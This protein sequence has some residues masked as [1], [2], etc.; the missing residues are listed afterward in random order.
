[1]MLSFVICLAMTS[2]VFTENVWAASKPGRIKKSSIK[3]TS[4]KTNSAVVKYGKSKGAKKYQVAYKPAG[5]KWK[6]KTTKK[7]KLILKSLK[8][9]TKY[10]VKVRGLRGK[11]TKGKWSSAVVFTTAADPSAG[12]STGTGED[13]GENAWTG[14]VSW[15]LPNNCR[16]KD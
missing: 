6:Y 8:A 1:M 14:G 12:E 10:R 13:S 11:K 3:V 5:G 2:L 9:G 7:R 4:V 16:D 15:G